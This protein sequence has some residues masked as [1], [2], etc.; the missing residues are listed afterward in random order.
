[1]F[2]IDD[3]EIMNVNFDGDVMVCPGLTQDHPEIGAI[4][5]CDNCG[6]K[7]PIN[8]AIKTDDE[9]QEFLDENNIKTDIDMNTMIRF[10]FNKIESID[11]VIWALNETKKL[12]ENKQ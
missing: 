10:R 7:M 4:S 3:N 12:M 2:Y 1:M 6:K 5:F 9:W 8:E 11:T